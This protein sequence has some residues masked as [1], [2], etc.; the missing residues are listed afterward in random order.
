MASAVPSGADAIL[1]KKKTGSAPV[2]VVVRRS[3]AR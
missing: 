2:F 1:Q 3:E